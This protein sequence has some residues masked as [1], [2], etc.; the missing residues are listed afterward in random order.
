MRARPKVVTLT[1]E[2]IIRL[3]DL[4]ASGPLVKEEGDDALI[5]LGWLEYYDDT[6]AMQVAVESGML[7]DSSGSVHSH[8]KR[9]EFT[10]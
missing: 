10:N 8:L 4:F 6:G 2:Q 1:S 9:R 7:Y 3:Q 5:K